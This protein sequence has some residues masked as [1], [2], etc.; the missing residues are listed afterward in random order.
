MT[1]MKIFVTSVAIL[2]TLCNAETGTESRNLRKKGGGGKKGGNPGGKGDPDR[3]QAIIDGAC[4]DDV[5][6]PYDC[7]GDTAATLEDF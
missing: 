1:P 4:G 6:V 7:G 5:E 3:I 2:A